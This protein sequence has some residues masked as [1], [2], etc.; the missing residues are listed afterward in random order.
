[1]VNV[2]YGEDYFERMMRDIIFKLPKLF[3]A[4]KMGIFE[5]DDKEQK[6]KVSIKKRGDPQ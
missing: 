2:I 5:V 1:M 6:I 4:K 3:D